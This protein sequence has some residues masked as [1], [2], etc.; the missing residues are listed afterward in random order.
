M[1]FTDWSVEDMNPDVTAYAMQLDVN[2]I[3]K[4]QQIST[5]NQIVIE[6]YSSQLQSGQLHD[7]RKLYGCLMILRC[8]RPI[9]QIN[10]SINMCLALSLFIAVPV[11]S[12][13]SD[14]SSVYVLEGTC[15]DFC[16]FQRFFYRIFEMFRQCGIFVFSFYWRLSSVNFSHFKL[17]LRNHWAN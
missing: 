6:M 1:F 15:I 14:R 7:F 9:K 5:F 12:Q 11:P 16:D 10:Q 13:E 17:L 4:R 2:K 8:P 3:K